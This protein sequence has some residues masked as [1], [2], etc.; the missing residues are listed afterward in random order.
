[1]SATAARRLW[2]VSETVTVKLC[3]CGCGERAPISPSNSA[4]GYVKGAPRRFVNGHQNR[5]RKASAE[6]RRRMSE[7]RQ[8]AR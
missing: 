4:H 1:M 7:G 2:T 6:H 5:G 8:K 3:E